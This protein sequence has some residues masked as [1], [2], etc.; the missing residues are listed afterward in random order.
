MNFP[1]TLAVLTIAITLAGCGS[2]QPQQGTALPASTHRFP[3]STILPLSC[4]EM[5]KVWRDQDAI[6]RGRL[7]EIAL[8]IAVITASANHDSEV[9]EECMR[10][11]LEFMAWQ[12]EI[13]ARYCAGM[14][15]DADA[16]CTETILASLAEQHAV[17]LEWVPFTKL[18][19]NRNWYKKF[20]SP[21]ISRVRKSLTEEGALLEEYKES[22]DKEYDEQGH[23]KEAKPKKTGRVKLAKE[24][25]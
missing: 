12:E 15:I 25:L 7:G 23:P 8:R 18:C 1:Q 5:M 21:R 13:R 22:E 16:Q 14:G 10:R 6:R 2:S 20:S 19:Q 9:S 17:G 24:D 4:I 3:K 11:A